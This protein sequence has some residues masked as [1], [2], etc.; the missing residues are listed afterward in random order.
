M[1]TK[2][3]AHISCKIIVPLSLLSVLVLSGCSAAEAKANTLRF[4]RIISDEECQSYID[5]ANNGQLDADGSYIAGEL[6]DAS[7]FL[8]PEGSV[9]V[10]FA[11]NNY[12]H[13]QYYA[14]ADLKKPVDTKQCYLMPGDRIYASEPV[15][16]HPSSKWYK[17]DRFCVYAHDGDGKRAQELSW[18]DAEGSALVLRVPEEPAAAEISVTPMGIY[19]DRILE[20]TDH[21][22]DSMG[23][24]QELS[25]TWIVN[26]QETASAKIEVS[27]VDPLEV[28]FH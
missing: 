16:D 7:E 12:I 20:L 22:I 18:N 26:D 28:D 6:N 24:Q 25:G 1:K 9:H 5:L 10:T 27:P 2:F 14:D 13:V 19:E 21:C 11:Q 4:F 23:R 15:C 17:F 3:L 8:P